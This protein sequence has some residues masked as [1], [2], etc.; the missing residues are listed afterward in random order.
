M[1]IPT[2][3]IQTTDGIARLG[4]E[5]GFTVFEYDGERIRFRAPYSLER[6]TNVKEWDHGYL[7]VDA[8]YRHNTEPEEEY[9]DLEPVLHDLYINADRFLDP[10][11]KVEV[12]HA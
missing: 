12:S 5:N 7:V 11:R 3:N 4:V 8:Q 6:Y 9:I 2:N 10:I 1:S